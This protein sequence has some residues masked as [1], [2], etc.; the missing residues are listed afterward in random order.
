MN[1]IVLTAI[2]HLLNS[3]VALIDKFLVTSKQVPK[4]QLYVF[5]SGVL[6]FLSVLI[7]ALDP[8]FGSFI[9][10]ELPSI[11][12]ISFP[13]NS[14][15]LFSV[16]SALNA[17]LGLYYMFKAFCRA[18]ASD[19]VPVVA[20][21]SAFFTLIISFLLLDTTLSSN[22]LIGFVLLIVGTFLVSRF[23]F[24]LKT[25]LDTLLSGLFFGIN[26][27]TLKLVF[28]AVGFDNGIFW[29][30]LFMTL[31]SLLMLFS[32][33]IRETFKHHRKSKKAKSSFVLIF[34]NKILAGLAG[35]LLAKAISSGNVSIVQALGGLQFVFLF[36]LAI[37]IGPYTNVDLG[38]NVKKKDIVQKLISI[39]IIFA[40]F[41]LLFV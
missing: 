34:S 31:L 1:F 35:I 37:L 24:G 14:V 25:F 40:G 41:V 30:S 16:F 6:A 3:V 20:S 28:N 10:F 7:F 32:R 39:G 29:F 23:R 33:D 11:S 4:P 18:D 27:T 13:S 17:L 26:A 19:V 22:F 21:I 5:Y 36:I 38:E 2:A 9:S 8:L 15:L 12:N